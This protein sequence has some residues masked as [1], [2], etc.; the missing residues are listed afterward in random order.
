MA[1]G[2]AI[3]SGSISFGMVHIPVKLSA[4]TEDGKGVEFR[5]VRRS[6][7]SPVQYRR[8]AS[9][10]GQ[11]V[12]YSDLAKGLEWGDEILVFDDA[13]MADLPLPSLKVIEI[14]QFCPRGDISPMM[15]DKAYHLT[16]DNGSN[17]AYTLLAVALGASHVVGIGVVAIRQRERL[18]MID[19]DVSTGVISLTTLLWPE[20]VREAPPL[21]AASVSDAE[22]D[23]ARDLVEVMSAPFSPADYQDGYRAAVYQ[24]AEAKAS[25]KAIEKAAEAITK[26]QA[27]VSLV[28]SLAASVAAH[29]AAKNG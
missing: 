27:G 5:Q 12:A 13:D 10:D 11:E 19:V 21:D 28:E 29:R 26:A 24:I 16:P 17:H 1:L 6:D 22:L 2:R 20:D 4:A 3:W 18:A 15:Y 14:R 8:F 9:A 23:T 7:G 25:G